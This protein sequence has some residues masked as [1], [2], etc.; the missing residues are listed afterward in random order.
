V[1][2]R[3]RAERFLNSTG[4]H[5]L[6]DPLLR[7]ET[8]GGYSVSSEIATGIPERAAP[9]RSRAARGDRRALAVLLL[10]PLTMLSGVVWGV[11]QPYRVAFLEREGKGLYDYLVQPPLLVFLVGALFLLLVARGLA[12]DL[13][14]EGHGP[15]A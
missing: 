3:P 5:R 12:D 8:V 9:R 6:R 13:E 4:G 2:G 11:A 1:V 15:A 10:G 14:S 7:R